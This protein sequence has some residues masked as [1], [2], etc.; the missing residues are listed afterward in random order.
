MSGTDLAYAA[1]RCVSPAVPVQVLHLRGTPP[2]PI[3]IRSGTRLVVLG[4]RFASAGFL[5]LV[6]SRDQMGV[7]KTTSG[8]LGGLRGAGIEYEARDQPGQ[9]LRPVRGQTHDR[10][11]HARRTPRPGTAAL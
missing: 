3:P 5:A 10:L 2:P 1:P 9:T 11:A 7:P 6:G 4:T 8:Y